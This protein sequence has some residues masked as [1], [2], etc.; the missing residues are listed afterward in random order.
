MRCPPGAMLQDGHCNCDPILY[1]DD[2][3]I[4]TCGIDQSA[5]HRPVNTWINSNKT[6]YLDH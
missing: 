5:I 4:D 3:H 6:K 1:T 2:I